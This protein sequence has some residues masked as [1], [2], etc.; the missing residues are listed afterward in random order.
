MRQNASCVW[1][2]AA[3]A[4]FTAMSLDTGNKIMLYVELNQIYEKK[5]VVHAACKIKGRNMYRAVVW[6]TKR[7]GNR[8]KE[9]VVHKLILK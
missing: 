4:L 3:K 7:E 6:E 1:L 9:L 2:W 8:L 5:W